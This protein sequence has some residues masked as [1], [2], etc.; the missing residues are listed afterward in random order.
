MN[1]RDIFIGAL[2]RPEPARRAAYLEQ[3]CAGDEALR[4]RVE[5][6]LGAHAEVGGILKAPILLVE[7]TDQTAPPP[8]TDGT[9]SPS[10]PGHPSTQPFT[11][12]LGTSS[13]AETKM[14]PEQ[15]PFGS[16]DLPEWS[17][18]SQFELLAELGRGG[19]GVVYKARHRLLNRVVA[20]KMISDGKHALP[21]QRVRFL[22]EAEAVARLHHPNILQLYDIGEADGRLFVSL[23]MLEGGSLADRLKGTTQPGRAAAELMATLASAMHAAHQ[24]GIVHRD[25]KP[26][27]VLFDGDGVLKIADFGLAKRLEVEDSQTQTGQVMGTPSYM[28]P[29]QAQGLIH[30]IGPPAD[31]YALGAILYEMLTGRPPFK[32]P[33]MMETLRQVVFEDVVPPSR[34]QSRI[35]RDL[36]TI[37]L[38]CLQKEPQKRYGSAAEL[39]DDLRRYLADLPIRARRTPLWERGAKWARRYPTT[40]TLS[41]LGAA[42]VVALIAFGFQ[43]DAWQKAE[44]LRQDRQIA[45]LKDQCEQVLFK[46]QVEVLKSNWPEA[47]LTL[48]NLLKNELKTEDPRLANLRVRAKQQFALAESGFQAEKEQKEALRHYGRFLQR[49]GEAY[50]HETQFTGLDLPTNLQATRAAT[51]EALGH[52]AVP[53]QGD[54]WTLSALPASLSPREKTEI[55]EG[56]YTLLLD[57]A[58]AVSQAVPGEDPKQQAERGLQ[59]LEQARRLRPESSKAYHLRRAACLAR[60]KDEA[61][62]SREQ[63]EAE[64][65]PPATTLDYFLSGKDLF[66]RRLWNKAARDFDAVM[67]RQPDHFW[68]RCLSAICALQT[69]QPLAA[70]V[71][72]NACLEH[73]PGFAWLY[74]LR[75][76]A[77]GQVAAQALNAAKV[78]PDQAD[79]LRYGAE[80]QF[81]AA[82]ADY[83]TA[84]SILDG[85]PKPNEGLSY[86]LLVNRGL[87]RFERLRLDDAVADLQE[88]IRRNDRKFEAFA[89]LAQ[90]FQ[91]QKKWDDAVELFTRAIRL[92]SDWAPLYRGR[93]AVQQERDD[94]TPMQR[95][96]ALRD[97]D[98]AIEREVPGNPVLASDLTR[99]G[100]LLRRMRRYQEAL[101][102]CD[103]AL[104]I[105]P[106]HVDAHRLRV[107]VLMDVRRYDE[108]IRSCDGA[109]AR[110]NPWP[111][112]HEIR[113]LAR[114]AREDF[115]GAIQDYTLA[116]QQRP[117]QPRVLTSRGLTYLVSDAPKLALSDF[118]EALGLDPS[119]GEA[120]SGRGSALVRLGDHHTA[121]VEAEESLRHGPPTQ[122]LVYNAARIYAQAATLATSSAREKGRDAVLLAERYQDRAVAL[123]QET[124]GRLPAEHRA[125]FWRDQVQDDPALRSLQR[126][127]R[128][129]PVI[130]ITTPIAAMP[131]RS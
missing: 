24:A 112:L 46:A 27:N 89:A 41:G 67:E 124:L 94:P 36:E 59:I 80:I 120:H 25:L 65:L 31:I 128:A 21:E 18:L 82:E 125:S 50:F 33:N 87:M 61:G 110:G 48:S 108:V 29:E 52:Y 105:L 10:N 63:A 83:R 131:A 34:L 98:E 6:L 100:D 69:K 4:R 60:L 1:E 13:S 64:R 54:A 7:P 53:G 113:G 22:I 99:R 70:K 14:L 57:L 116:L 121:V 47:K 5:V 23:E 40:A 97:L 109:L 2:Q 26:S 43:Y 117:G 76:Y 90:V 101:S 17:G 95:A 38:K 106:N 32:G 16:G 3:A 8:P 19:M 123:I 129:L 68:A 127:L 37:C 126:R 81:E 73:E 85:Q 51:R 71:G 78:L 93:A 30:Q 75:G 84:A 102:A 72:L 92:K 20:L 74:L 15:D 77:S 88:A 66:A 49:R 79:E 11:D 55:V 104:N 103:A 115:S 45:Q 130:P 118:E 35:S 39:A 111:D 9:R 86:V 91:K 58:E 56:C 122:R 114:A 42:V 12:E 44:I 96:A 107:M 62:A 28:A 119:S